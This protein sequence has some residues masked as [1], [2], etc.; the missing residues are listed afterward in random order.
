MSNDQGIKGIAITLE[1]RQIS[2]TWIIIF[3]SLAPQIYAVPQSDQTETV[4]PLELQQL[5]DEAL[6]AN[7]EIRVLAERLEALEHKVLPAGS[8]PDPILGFTLMNYP[9]TKNPF[10][11]GRIPMTQTQVSY[12]QK[13]PYPGK[14]RLSKEVAGWSVKIGTEEL[15]EK[16]VAI[17]SLVRDAYLRLYLIGRSLEIT[18]QNKSVLKEF[19]RIAETKF[20]VGKGLL[21]DVLKARVALS[22]LHSKI[23]QLRQQKSTTKARINTILNRDIHSPL[24]DPAPLQITSIVSDF[25]ISLD[26]AYSNRPELRAA[27]AMI[28]KNITSVDLARKNFMPDYTV[29]FAYGFRYDEVDFWTLG[30]SFNLPFFNRGSLREKLAEKEAQKRVAEAVRLVKRNK[31][32]LEIRKSLDEITRLDQQLRLYR[33]AI[34]PQA[35]MSLESAVSG[36]QVGKIDFLALLDSQITLFN[37]ELE[38]ERLLVEREMSAIALDAARGRVPGREK[39]IN[40]ND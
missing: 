20:E 32:A 38:L 35:E 36:Y 25:N 37:L 16:R 3:L 29:R 13:I 22:R 17:A 18:E 11:I 12:S 5:I 24:G 19:I 2:V 33:E 14:L 8:L 34:I 23:A 27:D 10:D 28:Q 39:E 26:E 1:S 30:V 4:E 15:A 6:Q 40:D 7:P 9:L 21:Q 31:V